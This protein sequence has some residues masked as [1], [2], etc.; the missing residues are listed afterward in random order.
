MKTLR[1]SAGVVSLV[2]GMVWGA[3]APA[4]GSQTTTGDIG[5]FVTHL[6]QRRA[7]NYPGGRSPLE[8][9]FERSLQRAGVSAASSRHL[10]KKLT[11]KRNSFLVQAS[12][13][14]RGLDKRRPIAGHAVRRLYRLD[15]VGTAAPVAP[16]PNARYAIRLV[17]IKSHRCADDAGPE[18]GCDKEE[19]YVAWSCFGSGYQRS[20]RTEKGSAITRGREWLF[21]QN[22]QVLSAAEGSPDATIPPQ[23]LFFVAQVAEEDPDGPTKEQITDA[24]STGAA[25]AAAVAGENWTV[26]VKEAP[27]LIVETFDILMRAASAGND[28]YPIY[29]SVFDA[30]KLATVTSGTSIGP[31]DTALFDSVGN[32]KG[33]SIRSFRDKNW[34]VLY[35]VVREDA[36]ERAARVTR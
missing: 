32:Y 5:L 15:D 16:I 22:T 34:T 28:L 36:M 9:R 25:V 31:E 14:F 11:A 19:P 4:R 29:Y 3:D 20:A 33:Y 35:M 24:A 17:G 27:G 2:V 26:V 23:T 18:G 1:K 10:Q 13:E 7:E 30:T 6:L 12:P 8:E 21:K